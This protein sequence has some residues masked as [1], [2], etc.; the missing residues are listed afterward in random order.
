MLIRNELAINIDRLLRF[1]ASLMIG[2]SG[3]G[4]QGRTSQISEVEAEVASLRDVDS[5][6]R[7]SLHEP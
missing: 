7:L 3:C 2:V 6:G 4:R 1:T 5:P